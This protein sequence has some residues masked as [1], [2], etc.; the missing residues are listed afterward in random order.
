MEED[1]HIG[2][3]SERWEEELRKF[4]LLRGKWDYREQ[5]EPY[6]R[7]EIKGFQKRVINLLGTTKKSN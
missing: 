3:K 5:E 4:S 1:T 6:T 7:R 2:E